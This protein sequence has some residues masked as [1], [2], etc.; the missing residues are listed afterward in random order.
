MT[1]FVVVLILALV[2]AVGFYGGAEFKRSKNSKLCQKGYY[3]ILIGPD[4][5]WMKVLPAENGLIVQPKGEDKKKFYKKGEPEIPWSQV[6]YIVPKEGPVPTVSYPIE[7]SN[8]MQVSV[9]MLIYHVGCAMPM[10]YDEKGK[11]IGYG[12]LSGV[13]PEIIA[14][15]YNSKDTVTLFGKATEGESTTPQQQPKGNMWNIILLIGL[16][17]AIA[18]G[19]ITLISVYGNA[20]ILNDIKNG[21]GL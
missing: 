3:C 21:F 6:G 17:G 7:A 16:I 5:V 1:L 4:R 12:V 10:G 18:V 20:G 11:F 14:G 2:V 19:V 8:R 15:I 13:A 9:G